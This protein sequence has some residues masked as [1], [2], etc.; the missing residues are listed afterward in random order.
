[1]SANA[2]VKAGGKSI[3]FGGKSL[4]RILSMQAVDGHLVEKFDLD[5]LKE[6]YGNTFDGVLITRGTGAKTAV[7]PQDVAGA[8]GTALR[9]KTTAERTVVIDTNAG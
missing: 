3:A 2:V 4:P 5:A 6:T 7:T 8:L 1:M 9:G